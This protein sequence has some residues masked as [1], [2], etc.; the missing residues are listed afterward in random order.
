MTDRLKW[1]DVPILL[2]AETA[3]SLAALGDALRMDPTTVSRRIAAMERDLGVT[4]FARSR[5]TL[6]LTPAGRRLLT[7]AQR[8]ETAARELEREARA[9]TEEPS[10][11]VRVSAPPTFSHT[12]LAPNLN[13]FLNRNPG[14]QVDISVDRSNVAIGDWETDVAIRLGGG[15]TDEDN[16]LARKLGE[17]PY[18]VFGASGML[19]QGRWIAYPEKFAHVPEAKWLTDRHPGAD[20]AARCND[21]VSTKAMVAAGAGLAVLPDALCLR[22]GSV[23]KVEDRI[24]VRDVWLLR[25]KASLSSYP[26]QL[27]IDWLAGMTRRVLNT[28]T[29]H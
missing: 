12:V 14:I 18:S 23:R 3:P 11:T 25:H 9:V 22:D 16:V 29:A 20:I 15:S 7:F 4:V 5:G 27:L 8:M 28:S 13:E 26:T 24:L 10:G 19:D 17:M 2:A 6:T 21:P 1:A